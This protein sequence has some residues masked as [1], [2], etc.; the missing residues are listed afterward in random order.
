MS[1]QATSDLSVPELVRLL[2]EKLGLKSTGLREIRISP[3]ISA[4]AL[5]PEVSDGYS[6]NQTT[7]SANPSDRKS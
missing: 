4:S 6:R 5:E 2:N 1:L 7:I 3:S